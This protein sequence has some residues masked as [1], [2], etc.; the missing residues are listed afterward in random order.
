MKFVTVLIFAL[1]SCKTIGQID[2]EAYEK[3]YENGVIAL[4]KK[5]QISFFFNENTKQYVAKVSHKYEK[6]HLET[7]RSNGLI[8]V[9]F[10]DFQSLNLE[11]ARYYK[12][13]SVGNKKLKENVKVKYADVKDYYINNV[14]YSDLKVKQFNCSVGLPENYVVNY[15]YTVNYKD[16]KFLTSF[17]FQNLDEAVDNVEISIKKNPNIQCSVFEFNLK[18]ITKSEDANYIKF[19]GSGLKRFKPLSTSVSPSY[20]LPHIVISVA[21]VKTKKGAIPVLKTT[22]DLYAWYKTLIEELRPE[23]GGL[24]TLAKSIV[25]GETDASK[26]IE[27]IFKWVQN[28]I[29][30]VAFENGIAGFKPTEAQT[31]AS[32]KYGDCKGMANL[33]VR[34]LKT[35]GYDARHTWIGTRANNY[36]YSMPSLVVDN[37]MICA[38]KFNDQLYYLDATSKSATWHKTPAHLE[39]KQAMVATGDTYK[40]YNIDPS[41]PE[42]NAL[43]ITGK[44]DVRQQASKIDLQFKFKGHFYRDFLSNSLYTSV[45]R[46][47]HVPYY[48]LSKYL[49]GIKVRTIE[50]GALSKDMVTFNVSGLYT[51]TAIGAKKIIFPFLDLMIYPGLSEQNPPNY[52]S[53]PQSIDSKIEVYNNGKLPK[54][55]YNSKLTDN[56]RFKAHYAATHQKD[57]VVIT[58]H[59]SLDILNSPL[60]T[61]KAWNVFFN[62]INLC[63]TLPLSYD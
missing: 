50:V 58:Q 55:T 46:K 25:K 43:T 60:K 45:N 6:L 39:G 37:H 48:F 34:L 28:N 40:V 12:I 1:C 16:L 47:A 61:N 53:Y 38:L 5:I 30:Y 23:E 11:K 32:V 9:P 51:N 22:D 59:I 19:K 15:A 31:V 2:V 3:K 52:I 18:D 56:A 27:R 24:A 29:Q 44:I 42:H 20:Y 63:N 8:Q 33:L 57:R 13:D 14:F 4:K 10:N 41:L 49:E 7:T 36:S 26:K 35:Q 54:E 21:E 62:Q 17:Y